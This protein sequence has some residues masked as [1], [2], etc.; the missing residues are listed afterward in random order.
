MLKKIQMNLRATA[1]DEEVS[2]ERQHTDVHQIGK[3]AEEW[4]V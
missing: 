2:H 4:E 3:S 1:L